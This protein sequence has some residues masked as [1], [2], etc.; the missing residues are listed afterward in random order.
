MDYQ[1]LRY[2]QG[3]AFLTINYLQYKTNEEIDANAKCRKI[4]KQRNTIVT[5]VLST[6]HYFF[7]ETNGVKLTGVLFQVCL[8]VPT[9]FIS[10]TAV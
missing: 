1:G 10:L 3:L 9:S 8:L 5:E 4:I 6:L 2:N 7:T